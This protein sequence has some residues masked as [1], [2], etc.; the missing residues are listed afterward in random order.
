MDADK[1][2]TAATAGDA[3]CLMNLIA[4]TP[5]SGKQIV[6]CPSYVRASGAARPLAFLMHAGYKAAIAPSPG[7]ATEACPPEE[8]FDC[9]Y[10][11]PSALD[12]KDVGAWARFIYCVGMG[13]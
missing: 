3:G 13:G 9:A 1:E 10:P 8:S 12:E 4:Y 6:L 2:I 5:E 11:C 7:P